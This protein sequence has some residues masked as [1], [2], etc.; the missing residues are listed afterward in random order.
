[1]LNLTT[2]VNRSGNSRQKNWNFARFGET[3]G[4]QRNKEVAY[5]EFTIVR[6]GL[7]PFLKSVPE[8]I[9]VDSRQ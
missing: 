1:M 8:K 4:M 5:R 2:L 9:R 6:A 3:A 7:I